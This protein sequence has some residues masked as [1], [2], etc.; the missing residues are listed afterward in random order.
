MIRM[1][2]WIITTTKLLSCSDHAHLLKPD[3][4]LHQGPVDEACCLHT[5]LHNTTAIADLAA[6]SEKTK[7]KY[8]YGRFPLS[9]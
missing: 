9:G 4:S 6:Y 7:G 8:A 1:G 2:E 3:A 5:K